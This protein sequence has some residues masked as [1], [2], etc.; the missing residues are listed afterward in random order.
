[1]GRSAEDAR[2]AGY[3]PK[4]PSHA[5]STGLRRQ[6]MVWRAQNVPTPLYD[7]FWKRVRC[8]ARYSDRIGARLDLADDFANR[9]SL[10]TRRGQFQRHAAASS[11][12][13]RRVGERATSG[14]KFRA[15]EGERFKLACPRSVWSSA[16]ASCAIRCVQLWVWRGG[17]GVFALARHRGGQTCCRSWWDGSPASESRDSLG[18]EVWLTPARDP[19][20]KGLTCWSGVVG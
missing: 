8:Q 9:A 16:R 3:S 11:D 14:R 5:A 12:C 6:Q 18:C 4:Y 17:A 1:M 15:G 10:Q 2:C 13:A 20:L 7:I 19:R